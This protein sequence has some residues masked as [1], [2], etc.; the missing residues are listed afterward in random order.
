M[1]KHNNTL[2]PACKPGGLSDA[3]RPLRGIY[4]LEGRHE[5]VMYSATT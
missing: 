5:P 4:I 2:G 3:R 1:Y